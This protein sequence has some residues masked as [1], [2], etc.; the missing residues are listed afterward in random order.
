[1]RDLRWSDVSEWLDPDHGALHD[2]CVIGVVPGAWQAVADLVKA[3]A[4][5]AREGE[6]TLL[7][8]PAEGFF[9]NFFEVPDE[10]VFDVHV[11]ELQGQQRLDLLSA[12]LRELGQ[13][14]AKPVALA[15]E[16]LDPAQ[17][18]YLHYDPVADGFV[19]DR[20]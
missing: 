12:F 1:M 11:G 16:G 15:F 8:S 13:V 17:E 4:W 2:G 6:G 19:L 20:R 18:P 5:S 14:W 10:V 9:V 7:V 3:R